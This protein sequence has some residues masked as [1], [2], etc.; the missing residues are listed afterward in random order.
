MAWFE[1][2]RHLPNYLDTRRI[3][4]SAAPE[5]TQFP[6]KSRSVAEGLLCFVVALQTG[7]GSPPLG[8]NVERGPQLSRRHKKSASISIA[9]HRF[10]VD[11][12]NVY[13]QSLRE[14]DPISGFW[15]MRHA[16]VLLTVTNQ[17]Q[18]LG[19]K[20]DALLRHRHDGQRFGALTT[21]TQSRG[22][23]PVA[24]ARCTDVGCTE[25]DK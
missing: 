18:T 7:L 5:Q 9:G 11:R 24:V 2:K 8:S 10:A 4:F 1:N 16:F 21:T 20:Q 6:E 22:I 25:L 3:H 19:G 15:V 23:L 13:R 17:S 14:D 12:P